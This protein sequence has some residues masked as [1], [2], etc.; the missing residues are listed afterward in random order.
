MQRAGLS[1]RWYKKPGRQPQKLPTGQT[2]GNMIAGEP[3]LGLAHQAEAHGDKRQDNADDR[4]AAKQAAGDDQALLLEGSVLGGL[5]LVRKTGLGVAVRGP[6][7]AVSY[8][9]LTLPTTQ[10][11]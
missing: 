7:V 9:H 6:L 11:V 10:T 4:L 8:T 3:L 1:L 2:V 5:L